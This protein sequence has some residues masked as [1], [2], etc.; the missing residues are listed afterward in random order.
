MPLVQSVSAFL[1]GLFL[2]ITDNWYPRGPADGFPGTVGMDC[3][4]NVQSSMSLRQRGDAV[5]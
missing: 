1:S 5:G 3:F 4:H 2:Q